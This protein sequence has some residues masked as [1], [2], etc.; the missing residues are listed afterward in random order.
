[1]GGDTDVGDCLNHRT[2]TVSEAGCTEHAQHQVAE[3]TKSRPRPRDG[4]RVLEEGR[5]VKRSSCLQPSLQ[6][7]VA[8]AEFPKSP[9]LLLIESIFLQYRGLQQHITQPADE[10]S[11]VLPIATVEPDTRGLE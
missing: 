10:L 4:R 5:L 9:P 7:G 6:P 2:H 3:Q 8:F 11:P 1:M